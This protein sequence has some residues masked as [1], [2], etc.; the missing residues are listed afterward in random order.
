MDKAT[1]EAMHAGDRM[2]YEKLDEG[3]AGFSKALVALEELLT[4][5]LIKLEEQVPVTV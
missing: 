1:F 3:I 4:E 5:R 2:A